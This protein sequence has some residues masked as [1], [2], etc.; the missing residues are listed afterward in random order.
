VLRVAAIL[1]LLAFAPFLG[2][3]TLFFLRFEL[4]GRQLIGIG[5]D[6]LL[7]EDSFILSLEA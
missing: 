4:L 2:R 6:S 3:Q 7:K 5:D 1:T